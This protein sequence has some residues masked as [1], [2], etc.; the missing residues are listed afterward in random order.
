MESIHLLEF[1]RIHDW[2]VENQISTKE[3]RIVT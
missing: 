2:L 3:C 1:K